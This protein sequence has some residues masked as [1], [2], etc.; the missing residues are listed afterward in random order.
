M[1]FRVWDVVRVKPVLGDGD[2]AASNEGR[3]GVV[4]AVDLTDGFDVAVKLD[5]DEKRP[6]ETVFF[7]IDSL[8]FL[9]R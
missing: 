6:Q 3:I 5:G 1:G 4:E 2:E 9:S 7:K 8:E